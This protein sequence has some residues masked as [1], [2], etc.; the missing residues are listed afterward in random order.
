MN[1]RIKADS[2]IAIQSWEEADKLLAILGTELAF[3]EQQEAE[4]DR[5]IQGA[6]EEL[7]YRVR[8]AQERIEKIVRSLEAF[9]TARKEDFGK[10]KSRQLNFGTLGWRKSTSLA[11]SKNTL[12]KIKEVFGPQAQAYLRIKETPD[13]DALAKLS[14]EQLRAIAARRVV[15]DDFFAEPDRSQAAEY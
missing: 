4:A 14:D 1:K 7:L 8:P 6:K 13:K 11:L 10:N 9:C 15:R 12:E 3:I 2:L 5:I